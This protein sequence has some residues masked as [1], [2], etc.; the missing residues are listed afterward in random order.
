MQRRDTFQELISLTHSSHSALK[1]YAASHIHEFFNDF[2]DLEE[3]AIN[4]VYDLC[5]D[6]DPNVCRAVLAVL[7]V[8]DAAVSRSAW[9]GTVR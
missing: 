4:A 2:P 1:S 9:M 7:A 5:E 8:T 6:Q 3:D